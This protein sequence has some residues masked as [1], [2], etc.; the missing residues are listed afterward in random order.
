M[1]AQPADPADGTLAPGIPPRDHRRASR[2]SRTRARR[3][4]RRWTR[5]GTPLALAL[6]GVLTLILLA[7]S[8]VLL[9]VDA[10]PAWSVAMA[11]QAQL[12]AELTRAEAAVGVPA[13]A[14]AGIRRSE[15]ATAGNLAGLL[16]NGQR[17]AGAY[18]ALDA[19]VRALEQDQLPTLRQR[20]S[21]DLQRVTLTLNQRAAEQVPGLDAYSTA[22]DAAE[23]RVLGA[24]SLDDL[25]AVDATL[26]AQQAALDAM[27]PAYQQLSALRT[28][29]LARR[30]AGEASTSG[31]ASYAQDLAAFSATST[32][33]GYVALSRQLA[34]Q[35]A[36]LFSGEVAALIAN[37]PAVLGA[38]Q[39]RIAVLRQQG[40]DAS[41]FQRAHDA[42]A[43]LLAAAHTPDDYLALARQYDQTLDAF[44]LPALRGQAQGDLSALKA[45]IARGQALTTR[46]P[47]NGRG[48]P[49]AYEYAAPDLG[50]GGLGD[51]ERQLAVASSPDDLQDADT[52]IQTLA[53]NLTAMLANLTDHTPSSQ[54]HKTDLQLMSHYN[55]LGGKVVVISLREQ[56]ARFY[57]AGKLV[58]WSYITTGRPERPTPPGLHTATAKL[59]PTAFSSD[60]PPSSPLWVPYTTPIKYAIG[61]YPGGYYLHDGWWRSWFGPGSNLPHHEPAAFNGGSH[62]CINFSTKMMAWVYAWTP[63]GTPILVY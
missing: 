4:R 30:L 44:V 25:L 17:A 5:R 63:L 36:Q 62:G 61:F 50:R 21:A 58:N 42:Q 57:D 2:P 32:A 51:L 60:E 8:L 29:L 10:Q 37:G 11:T 14:L 7:V 1:A 26:H 48:Y 40:V 28:T 9:A 53:T 46:D 22:L 34:G 18:S 19:Q 15:H 24:R 33:A 56:T 23:Q 54:P 38:L 47:A 27:E 43:R 13:T 20:V 35:R 3:A 55:L 49:D 59:S 16:L 45:L 12:D 39:A 31:E 6:R 41:S 52:D